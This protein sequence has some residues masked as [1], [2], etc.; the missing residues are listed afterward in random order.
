[1]LFGPSAQ[2]VAKGPLVKNRVLAR[3]LAYEFGRAK[4]PQWQQRVSSGAMYTL[5]QAT[6]ILDQRA[7]AVGGA[8]LPSGQGTLGCHKVKINRATDV[9]VNQDCSLRRQ[10]EETIAVNPLNSKNLIAGQNDSRVGFNHCGYDW[11]LDGGNTWG[12]QIPP[13]FQFI[14]GDGHT[15]DACSDPT[16]A[17]D[18]KGNAYA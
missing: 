15:A 1:A 2:P 14:L 7:A 18:S 8:Q 11:S 12:D 10:A 3:Q 5:L 13:F 6:G 17:F 9:R 4:R 16:A